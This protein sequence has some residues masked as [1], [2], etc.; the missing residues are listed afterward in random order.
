[1]R[2]HA[3]RVKQ[4]RARRQP[5]RPVPVNGELSADAAQ[6]SPYHHRPAAGHGIEAQAGDDAAAGADRNR[7]QVVAVGVHREMLAVAA[8]DVDVELSAAWEMPGPTGMHRIAE[9]PSVRPGADDEP[10]VDIGRH[11]DGDAE[12][13]AGDLRRGAGC[14]QDAEDRDDCEHAEIGNRSPCHNSFSVIE[15]NG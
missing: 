2:S 3:P 8:D 15:M 9:L 12:A 13:G 7:R 1:M 11:H 10:A 14:G 4:E 6:C 5:A